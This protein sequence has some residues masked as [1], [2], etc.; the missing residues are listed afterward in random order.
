MTISPDEITFISSIRG[1]PASALLAMLLTGRAITTLELATLTGYSAR[2]M[3]AALARLELMG[4]IRP[5]EG[6]DGQVWSLTRRVPRTSSAA[7]M[8]AARA[9][10][11][12]AQ[13]EPA[14]VSV[15]SAEPGLPVDKPGKTVD[16][17]SKTGD[18]SGPAGA[19]PFS[20]RASHAVPPRNVTPPFDRISPV[21]EWRRRE[22]VQVQAWLE[23]AGLEPYSSRMVELLSR[24][25][26]P[27]YVQPF[28]LECQYQRQLA[29][30]QRADGR[31]TD[32]DEP[33]ERMISRMRRGESP[34]P[35]R[36]PGC[37][38][39]HNCYCHMV[40]K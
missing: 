23:R 20:K 2:S 1:V 12:R 10:P 6:E 9:Q 31:A 34:P 11:P 7:E 14:Q 26:S 25:F 36:C 17:V 35:P 37:L 28:A 5:A 39:L 8:M 18:N 16:N 27:G 40:V 13:L 24:N 22:Q 4:L 19:S 38:C 3:H 15:I 33:I 29:R 30:A 21:E 32:L